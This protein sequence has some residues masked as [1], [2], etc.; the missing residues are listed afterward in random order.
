MQ[1]IL[2]L[3]LCAVVYLAMQFAQAQQQF[4]RID[5]LPHTGFTAIEVINGKVYAAS[6]N[7]LYSSG[8][9][10]ANWQ[11]H[12][13]T[14]QNV[15]ANCIYLFNNR[16]YV[17]TSNGTFNVSMN[18]LNGTWAQNLP[19]VDVTSLTERD[20]AMYA[21]GMGFGMYRLLNGAWTA[22]SSQLPTYSWNVDKILSTPAGLM[23]MAG[24]NGTFYI[25]STATSAW[26]ERYYTGTY[27]PGLDADDA[28][29]VNNTIYV[30]THNAL[31][32]TDNWGNSWINDNTGLINGQNRWLYKGQQSLYALTTNFNP[33]DNSNITWLQKRPVNAVAQIAWNN[34]NE[35]LPY[36]VYAL[37]ENG[38]QI[39]A[40]TH[41][42][43]Y[44]KT[45]ATLDNDKPLKNPEVVVYP[46][47]STGGR[48]T[49]E[50]SQHIDVLTVYDMTG[51]LLMEKKDVGISFHFILP[52][53]GI[54]MVNVGM[55]QLSEIFKVMVKE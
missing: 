38:S 7:R 28:I 43:L 40:A 36:Y 22:F 5:K 45:D 3:A 48:F 19:G 39:Y 27:A 25:Y 31:Y 54:Y 26:Q 30:S 35:F 49:I 37:R 4:T 13:M 21:S 1:N 2:K 18:N 9:N 46:N 34:T 24:A 12:T 42:G 50:S 20:G 11:L 52:T 44:V 53:A 17:G 32:R 47:P 8:D 41:Q 14:Q 51:K 55:G 23:A 10:G 29:I 6:G 16:L 33:G 15:F